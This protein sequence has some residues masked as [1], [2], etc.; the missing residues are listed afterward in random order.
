MK[1]KVVIVGKGNVGGALQRGLQ[2]AGYD[3]RAVGKDPAKVRE[4]AKWAEALILAVPFSAIDEVA[5]ELGD[6]ATGKTVIDTTNIYTPEAI[7]AVGA[8]SGAEVI[9]SKIPGARVVKAF[10]AQF[11]QN[12]ETGKVA[13]QP[14]TVLVAGDDKGA[15]AQAIELARDIGFDAVDAGPLS[16]AKLVEY[17]GN[18]IISLGYDVGMGTAIGFR[19]VH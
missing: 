10:N 13:G 17:S 4:T 1:L 8:R 11:A 18:L 16:N 19:L 15:K 7:A 14:L 3:A 9:Q 2:R 6:G 5:K 12:M